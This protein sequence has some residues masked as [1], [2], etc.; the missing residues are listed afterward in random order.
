[1]QPKRVNRRRKI[2]R[3]APIVLGAL[4]LG[5]NANVHAQTGPI[6]LLEQPKQAPNPPIELPIGLSI[7]GGPMPS[8]ATTDVFPNGVASGDVTRR[9][10]VLWARAAVPTIMVFQVS[11][12]AMFTAADPLRVRL[13]RNP[14][15]PGRVEFFGLTPDTRY[16]YRA[17]DVFSGEAVGG[18]FRTSARNGVHR[19]LRFGIAG[20]WQQAPPYPSLSNVAARDLELF[21]KLGD[22]IYADLETPAIPGVPQARTLE[23]FRTKHIEVASPRPE[24]PDFNVMPGLNAAQ[25][26]LATIDD[27]EI[28]DNFAGGAAPGDSP[29]APLVNPQEAP[30]FTDPVPFVNETQAYL[31]AL[32]AFQDFHPQSR[33]RWEGTADVRVEGR[34][35]LYRTQR[36]GNDATITLLDSRS[37][38]DAQ[39]PPVADPTDPTAITNFLIS[40]YD[41][42]RTLL[43]RPQ[44]ETLK[45][46]LLDAQLNG[47]TWK[48]VVIPEPIQNFGVVNAEDRFEGYAVERAE[49]LGFIAANGIKNVVFMAGDFH[50][51]LVNN[52]TFQAFPGAE[53]VQTGAIEIVTGPVSFFAGRFGPAVAGIAAAAG[54]ITPEE[55]AFYNSLPVAPDLDSIPNDKDDF[56]EGLINGQLAPLGLDPI[57]LDHNLPSAE[58]LIDA[59]LLVG[60]YVAA[61]SFAWAE[62]EID[63]ETQ[64]LTVTVWGIEA[65]SEQDFVDDPN[66]VISRIP[67]VITQFTVN[68]Q[69]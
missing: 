66:D 25:G 45:A 39:V 47:V 22:T 18:T 41:P 53:P 5:L 64:M 36:Y 12:D 42:T 61:H 57:G 68:P 20:D 62:L 35:K 37:F 69:P 34:P 15:R 54:L 33:Q 26:I 7:E 21:V 65:H 46:D 56:L 32:R 28:V 51:T 60:D 13:V 6:H 16:Y 4:G 23:Q 11:R 67:E 40:T 43:G 44:V 52:L 8:A 10:A 3:L 31:D 24:A 29:D 2:S 58:G 14:L 59:N 48:F 19:G 30:L 49:I 1:M 27:H 17:V 50:G 63:A 38:R 55:F 9:S